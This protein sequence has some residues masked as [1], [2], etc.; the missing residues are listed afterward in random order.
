MNK[1]KKYSCPS[2]KVMRMAM[3][4]SVMIDTFSGGDERNGI[5]IDPD[6]WSSPVAASRRCHLTSVAS[7]LFSNVTA[8]W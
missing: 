3:K 6:F 7:P 5:V 4:K 2:I 1:Q 8:T